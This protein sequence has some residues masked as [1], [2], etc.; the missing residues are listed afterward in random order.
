[1]QQSPSADE[2]ACAAALARL[3]S[4][5]ASELYDALAG[6]VYG[7][8]L[9]L[10]GDP[11]TAGAV[12]ADVFGYMCRN[13]GEYDPGRMT[14]AQ[15]TSQLTHRFAALAAV[16]AETTRRRARDS[17]AEVRLTGPQREDLVDAY[18]GGL[19]YR[20]IAHRRGAEPAQ[21][22]ASLRD[23]LRLDRPTTEAIR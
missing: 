21:I 13:Y 19:T 15:W 8:A 10:C 3:D 12:C 9:R 6:H 18:L 17:L 1:M 20:E 5:G 23:A 14:I 4:G 11:S 7:L 2:A 22:A 16:D